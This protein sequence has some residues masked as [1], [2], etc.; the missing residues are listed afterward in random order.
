MGK[1]FIKKIT[2]E[3]SKGLFLKGRVFDF[4]FS[5]EDP[6]VK[7]FDIAL[8]DRNLIFWQDEPE[9][10]VIGFKITVSYFGDLPPVECY[11]VL[12]ETISR[13]A[14]D[15]DI[16]EEFVLGKEYGVQFKV[17]YWTDNYNADVQIF[18]PEKYKSY[19]DDIYSLDD[20]V[21][22]MGRWVTVA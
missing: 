16:E 2:L 6:Y 20:G 13:V 15:L 3:T 22:R 5:T 10:E 9:T 12:E 19:M 17:K 8:E 4:E 14:F 21:G 11:L 18:D 7:N 1:G